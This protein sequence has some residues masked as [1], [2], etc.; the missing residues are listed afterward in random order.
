MLQ[1]LQ[2]RGTDRAMGESE[3]G[4][5]SFAIGF[6]NEQNSPSGSFQKTNTS[7]QAIDGALFPDMLNQ[8]ETHSVLTDPSVLFSS[9][10]VSAFLVATDGRPLAARDLL[11]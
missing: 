1:T 7:M 3:A 6:C 4:D 8:A 9:R 10:G 5:R 11:G 2:M